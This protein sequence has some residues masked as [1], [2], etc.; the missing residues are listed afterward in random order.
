MY[1]KVM[2]Q[3]LDV[4]PA[5]D[6]PTQDDMGERT[7][8][9]YTHEAGLFIKVADLDP[10]QDMIL[11]DDLMMV[12]GAIAQTVSYIPDDEPDTGSEGE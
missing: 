2:E 9:V 12:M 5:T 8:E 4:Y 3:T 10:N 11:W 1:N 6:N 7:V